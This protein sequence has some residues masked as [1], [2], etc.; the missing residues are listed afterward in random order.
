MKKLIFITLSIIVF[1][2]IWTACQKDDCKN[3]H[4]V[5]TN[6]NDSIIQVGTESEYCETDLDSKEN[7]TPETIGGN[8]TKWVCE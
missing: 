8:T 1:A 3:C 4:S 6:A 2:L 5:T 7:S